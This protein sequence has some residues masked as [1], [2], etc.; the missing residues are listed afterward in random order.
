MIYAID[1]IIQTNSLIN[2]DVPEDRAPAM[3]LAPSGPVV[4]WIM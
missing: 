3:A 1:R 2:T 4:F